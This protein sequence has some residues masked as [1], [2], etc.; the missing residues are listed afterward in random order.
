MEEYKGRDCFIIRRPL[1]SNQFKIYK[2]ECSARP[3]F[4]EGPFL[5]HIVLPRSISQLDAVITRL[6]T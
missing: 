2:E 6:P 3:S 5:S 1:F 4:I